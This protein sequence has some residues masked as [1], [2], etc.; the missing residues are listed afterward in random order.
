MTETRVDR[1]MRRAE[2]CAE[3]GE[4]DKCEQF[5]SILGP[6]IYLRTLEVQELKRL[7]KTVTATDDQR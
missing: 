1:L 7:T 5:V 2:E 6:A 4:Y 3:Q